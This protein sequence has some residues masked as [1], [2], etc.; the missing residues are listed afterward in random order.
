VIRPLPERI[1]VPQRGE[2][3]GASVTHE[4]RPQFRFSLPRLALVGAV[5]M[6]YLVPDR[7]RQCEPTRRPKSRHYLSR[8]TGGGKYEKILPSPLSIP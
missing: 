1:Q 7:R 2:L 3:V 5:Q 8:D 4:A 6:R